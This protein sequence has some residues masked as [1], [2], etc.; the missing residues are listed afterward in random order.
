MRSTVLPFV[1]LALAVGGIAETTPDGPR[2]DDLVA[3]P[4]PVATPV[5]TQTFA[6]CADVLLLA[7]GGGGERITSTN[8]V[9]A[10]ASALVRQYAARAR[11]GGRSVER[12]Y[13]AVDA[14]GVGSLKRSATFRGTASAAVTRASVN[15]WAR[16]V[17]AGVDAAVASVTEAA[18]HCPDQQVVLAGYSQGAMVMHR[19]LGRLAASA[20]LD[21]VVGAMLVSDGD[22]ISR[23]RGPILG[24][25]A[26][27]RRG[28]GVSTARRAPAN[29]LPTSGASYQ[30]WN[31]CTRGDVVCDLRDNRVAEAL[32]TSRTYDDASRR[33]QLR[34]IAQLA[35]DRSTGWPI[36]APRVV[37]VSRIAGVPLS[38][39]LAV[40]VRDGRE[41]YVRWTVLEGLPAGLTLSETGL[42]SGAATTAGSY[43]LL[44]SVRDASLAAYSHPQPGAVDLT[45]IPAAPA[46][47]QTGGGQS[48]Q[49]RVDSSLWCW[50]ANAYGQ[51]GDGT[52]TRR[53]NP[54][55][56]AS[57]GSW[58]TVSTGGSTTCGIKSDATLWCWGLNY[59]GQVGDGTRDNRMY[60]QKIAGGYASVSTNY[61]HSCGIKT[62]GAL[63]CWGANANGQLGDGTTD[64]RGRPRRVGDA[65]DW[66]SVT[67]GGTHTCGV[68]RDGSAWCWGANDFGQLGDGTRSRRLTPMRVGTA[69]DWVQ[70]SSAWLH[71]CGVTTGGEVRCWGDNREGQLG[72]GTTLLRTTPTPVVSDETFVDVATGQQHSCAVGADRT[73]WCW[74]AN[75]YGQLGNGSVTDAASPQMVA[76][77]QDFAQ[78]SASWLHTCAIR[79]DG[80][81]ACWG[82]NESAQLGT[83]DLVDQPSPVGVI[84]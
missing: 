13:V 31:L 16:G 57:A 66:V 2:A 75:N 60:P 9:G 74:G 14:P 22:R 21:R 77:E 80:R 11:A 83:G 7:A 33:P 29:A 44:Y 53:L 64:T 52:R 6:D 48:C 81:S 78:V 76:G 5:S 84:Q 32:V 12:R 8:P 47:V 18:T 54:T 51:L 70:L 58:E 36:P 82:A 65:V 50:G 71:T 15:L 35:W 43:R 30:V 39:Q 41:P 79:A 20:V 19:T 46:Q 61:F 56:V 23:T 55:K 3:R 37:T 69:Q 62:T 38:Q 1:L 28:Q 27:P 63:F 49:V 59:K 45:I 26:A 73:A 10:T 4:Q 42:L 24:A 40:N 72:D 17:D 68:R 67:T 25:P 34:E